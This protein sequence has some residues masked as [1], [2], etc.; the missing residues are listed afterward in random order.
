MNRLGD[1]DETV[2]CM[3]PGDIYVGEHNCPDRASTGGFL[4]QA[5]RADA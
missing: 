4:A 2:I 1:E 5:Q 3:G